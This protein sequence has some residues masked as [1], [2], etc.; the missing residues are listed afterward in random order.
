MAEAPGGVIGNYR[1]ISAIGSG[2]FSV[3]Y[4]AVDERFDGEVAIKVLADNYAFD[5][6][7]RERFISE[8][9]MLRKVACPAIVNVY[10]L[11]EN[12]GGQPYLVLGYADA[13]TLR[14][15]AEACWRQ[16]QQLDVESIYQVTETLAEALESVHRNGLVH[17]DIKPENILMF[18][19]GGRSKH[20]TALMAVGERMVLGDFGFAKD[21][22]ENSGPTVGG[23]T[24]G[25]SAPEQQQGMGRIDKRADI[26]GASSVLFWLVT[27]GDTPATANEPPQTRLVAAGVSPQLAAAISKGLADSAEQRQQTIEEWRNDIATCLRHSGP[28]TQ[29]NSAPQ[30]TPNFHPAPGSVSRPEPTPVADSTPT[31]T[32]PAQSTQQKSKLLPLLALGG[33]V[34]AGAVGTGLLLT[35]DDGNAVSSTTATT[36]SSTENDQVAAPT[37]AA[38]SSIGGDSSS[39]TEEPT[40]TESTAP[41]STEPS[42]DSGAIRTALPG[43]FGSGSY[44]HVDITITK[45]EI[46]NFD[47]LEY[48]ETDPIVDNPEDRFLYVSV[49]VFNTNNKTVRM[50]FRDHLKLVIDG[51]GPIAL[52]KDI[53]DDTSSI[54][55]T[56]VSERVWAFPLSGDVTLDQLQLSYS[57]DTVPMLFDLSDTNDGTAY[58]VVAE[59]DEIVVFSG[60]NCGVEFTVQLE[61]VSYHID[62]PSDIDG[63]DGRA[64]SDKRFAL[65]RG[66]VASGQ[67]QDSGGYCGN[68]VDSDTFRLIINDRPFEMK[69]MSYETMDPQETVEIDL[70]LQVPT[71]TQDLGLRVI[72][73]EEATEVSLPLPDLPAVP[74]E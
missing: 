59:M 1:I 17:R 9:R 4:R 6:A 19:T 53:S 45:I 73:D 5:P 33:I 23:G 16:S 44:N 35:R 18:S 24:I 52:D 48:E 31:S 25:F 70:Y 47:A 62:L 69:N 14:E 26:Y 43:P 34:L 38:Q 11:G 40:T 10:D 32:R 28:T 71:D 29:N 55:S 50:P 64:E 2:G 39:T 36:Q 22:T 49:E 15:R 37:T 60:V 8:A 21:L 56:S 72:N 57:S 27:R 58:P 63:N 65:V 3:V 74:G 54:A 61:S 7:V 66:F 30:P 51:G 13:G 42:D 20:P 67:Q 68:V 46:A 41:P 12:D